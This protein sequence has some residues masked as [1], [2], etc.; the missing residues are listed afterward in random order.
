M[1]RNQTIQEEINQ[2]LEYWDLE[3]LV[4]FLRDI[5]PLLELYEVEEGNDWVKDA[6]G[7]EDETTIR[8]IRTVYL[9]SKIAENHAGKLA[10]LKINFKDI[11][12]RMEKVEI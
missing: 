3:T 7:D 9:V 5:I 1:G 8:L 4:S 6:I 12:R 11:Y 10:S 2:F